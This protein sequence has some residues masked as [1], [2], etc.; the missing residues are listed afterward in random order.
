MVGR[1]PYYLSKIY[2]E[3]LA[4][5]LCRARGIPLVVLNPSLLL[6]PGDDRLSST[7]IVQKFLAR[8]VPA[9]PSG[10]LSLVDS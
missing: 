8:D 9:M 10:G 7:W 6:G 5:E 4:L 1:W 3:K 2:E